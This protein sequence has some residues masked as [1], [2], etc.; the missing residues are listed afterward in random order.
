[1]LLPKPMIAFGSRLASAISSAFARLRERV[2]SIA[3]A[4]AG[5]I[6]EREGVCVERRGG[7]LADS[8]VK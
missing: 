5:R 3:A 1:M 8:H 7:E 6:A 4:H 2:A